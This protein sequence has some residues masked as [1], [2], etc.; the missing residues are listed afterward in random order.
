[1]TSVRAI[2]ELPPGGR[3]ATAIKIKK[4]PI[5]PNLLQIQ[6]ER[7]YNPVQNLQKNR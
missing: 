4:I 5:D 3:P 2:P 6:G 1:M 7:V